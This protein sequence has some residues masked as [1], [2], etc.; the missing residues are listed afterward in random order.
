LPYEHIILDEAQDTNPVMMEVIRQQKA[1]LLLIGDRHQS[2]YG[3]R[4][5][6]NAMEIFS[7]MGAKVLKMPKTWRFGQDIADVA[8]KLL[9]HFKSEDTRIIGAGP[10]STQRSSSARAILSRTNAGLFREAADVG[11]VGVYWVGG[12]EGS[13]VDLLLDAWSLKCNRRNQIASP[14]LRQYTSWSQLQE[15]AEISKDPETKLLCNFIETYGSETPDLVDSFKRHA[16]KSEKGARLILSTA[17][18]SKGL[19]FDHVSIGSD[20]S[21]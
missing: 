9:G 21:V 4:K 19:D 15:E 13:R 14:M 5:A 1:K 10:A 8:N 12:I 17:H 16:L 7:A 20:L 18:K 3:F 6:N 11:G 2:I